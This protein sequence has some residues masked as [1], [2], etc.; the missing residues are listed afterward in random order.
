MAKTLCH[1]MLLLNAHLHRMFLYAHI[2]KKGSY[3]NVV[4]ECFLFGPRHSC[5]CSCQ[6]PTWAS[7]WTN[8]RE[9][10][11]TLQ[12][13][14]LKSKRNRTSLSFLHRTYRTLYLNVAKWEFPAK[15]HFCS[16]NSFIFTAYVSQ[17]AAWSVYCHT[18][19]SSQAVQ[20]AQHDSAV[21]TPASC[22]DW[23]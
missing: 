8:G 15:W 7:T 3:T 5:Q 17:H 13:W 22:H 10:L 18:L 6:I 23:V 11:P 2:P 4:G 16:G 14:A 21:C 12:A 20:R 1:N 9:L 19:Q